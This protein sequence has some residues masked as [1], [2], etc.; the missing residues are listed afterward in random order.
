MTLSRALADSFSGI[1]PDDVPTFRATQ[2]AGALAAG[3]LARM[4]SP[5]PA[6]TRNASQAE[7]LCRRPAVMFN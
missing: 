4:L 5:D 7:T 3:P 1:R 6:S 2:I